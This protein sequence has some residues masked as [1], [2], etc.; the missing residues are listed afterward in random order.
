MFLQGRSQTMKKTMAQALS[1]FFLVSVFVAGTQQTSSQTAT[2]AQAQSTAS[3]SVARE[4]TEQRLCDG[5]KLIQAKLGQL[6]AS[7]SAAARIHNDFKVVTGRIRT[8]KLTPLFEKRTIAPKTAQIKTGLVPAEQTQKL[9]QVYGQIRGIKND[10]IQVRGT[11]QAQLADLQKS[12]GIIEGDMKRLA[13]PAGPRT[14]AGA[15][16]SRQC[17]AQEANKVQSQLAALGSQSS[18][19]TSQI[20]DV[21]AALDQDFGQGPCGGGTTTGGLSCVVRCA[22]HYKIT[23]P[24]GSAE[25][26]TQQWERFQCQVRCEA[27]AAAGETGSGA[28]DQMTT[29]FVNFDGS[30]RTLFQILTSIS[31]DFHDKATGIIRNM[32]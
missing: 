22:E 21:N 12:W 4:A 8:E 5:L 10:L 25:Y 19:L 2:K 9:T 23:A 20:D 24:E 13:G 1:I 6:Q 31:K 30:A 11:L 26:S 17:V 14:I 15:S 16:P 3:D 28:R 29:A 18:N 32:I 7:V 27:A